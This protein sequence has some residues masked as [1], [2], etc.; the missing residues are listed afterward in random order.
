MGVERITYIVLET[1]KI[2]VQ[3]QVRKTQSQVVRVVYIGTDRDLDTGTG[4]DR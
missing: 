1:D 3:T 2:Q 4:G